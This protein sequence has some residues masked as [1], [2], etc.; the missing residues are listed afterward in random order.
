MVDGEPTAVGMRRILGA[1]I[2]LLL[3][4]AGMVPAFIVIAEKRTNWGFDIGCT[5]VA[6]PCVNIGDTTYSLTGGRL[7]FFAAIVVGYLVLVV[8]ARRG[9]T[10]RSVGMNVT[11]VRL[12]NAAGDPPGAMRGIV[13]SLAG[14]IDALPC[15]LPVVG[16]TSIA[17]GRHHQRVADRVAGTFVVHER[18]AG[19]PIIT[20]TSVEPTE[21]RT[22]S[23]RG[24]SAVSVVMWLGVAVGV[25]L[26]AASLLALWT[27]SHWID[28]QPCGS[29][30]SPEGDCRVTG[31]ALVAFLLLSFSLL[32]AVF[33]AWPCWLV[34]ALVRR[35]AR[36]RA[37][38]SAIAG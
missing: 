32:P 18:D 1:G 38:P 29:V 23:R 35:R 20:P 34:G 11:G 27:T 14:V 26:A 10:G 31:R 36:S 12:V 30:V 5:A 28:G 13:R 3:L 15:S 9:A 22:A 17:L 8:G 2:D 24:S 4:A 19:R 37:R 7:A 25:A 6:G 21:A 16:L 33:I